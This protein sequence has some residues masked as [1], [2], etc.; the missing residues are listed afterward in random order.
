MNINFHQIDYY[1]DNNQSRL[2]FFLLGD[3]YGQIICVIEKLLVYYFRNES[4]NVVRVNCTDLNHD[5]SSLLSHFQSLQLFSEKK[6]I[7]I[8]NIIDSFKE[9]CLTCI[10]NNKNKFFF[11]IQASNIKKASKI[12]KEFESVQKFCFINCYKLNLNATNSFIKSFFTKNHI[13]FDD[14]MVGLIASSLPNNLLIIKNEL[15]KI[16]QYLSYDNKLSIEIIQNVVSGVKDIEYI[17]ILYALVYKNSHQL[18]NQL[19]QLNNLSLLIV[20]RRIQKYLS[21]IVSIKSFEKDCN[22]DLKLIIDHFKPT[23]FFK[24]KSIILAIC[25]KISFYEALEF[26]GDLIRLEIKYKTYPSLSINLELQ[27]YLLEKLTL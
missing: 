6:T 22:Q 3:D 5:S 2:Y 26:M 23:I 1:L 20:I 25:K 16:V 21:Q 18:L 11:I 12:Y 24:E 17:N 10:N 13:N 19:S 27:Y 8:E 7:I 9:A 15:E 4:R 14:E